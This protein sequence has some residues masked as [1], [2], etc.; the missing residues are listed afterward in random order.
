[1]KKQT[2]RKSGYMSCVPVADLPAETGSQ[3]HKLT[4]PFCLTT[5]ELKKK[6]CEDGPEGCGEQCENWDVCMYGHAWVE[7]AAS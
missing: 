1:M 2:L 6:L 4:T 7:R 3:W 5:R